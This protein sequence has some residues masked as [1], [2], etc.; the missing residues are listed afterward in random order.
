MNNMQDILIKFSEELDY[1]KW[2]TKAYFSRSNLISPVSPVNLLSLKSTSSLLAL[3]EISDR[4]I[5]GQLALSTYH[6]FGLGFDMYDRAM[7]DLST[8]IKSFCPHHDPGDPALRVVIKHNDDHI[9]S[10]DDFE[11]LRHHVRLYAESLS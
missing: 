10:R 1:D 2:G 8:V 7:V 11:E 5:S 9:R 4:C 3:A 6:V